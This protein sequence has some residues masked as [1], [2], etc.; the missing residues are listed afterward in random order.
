V[1]QL[2]LLEVTPQS[3]AEPRLVPELRAA[4]VETMATAIQLVFLGRGQRDERREPA[5][6][7]HAPAPRP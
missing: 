5:P 6:E 1:Q 2:Q 7:D 4:L 3:Q